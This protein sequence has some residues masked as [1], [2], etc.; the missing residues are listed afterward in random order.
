MALHSVQHT[1]ILL[2][3]GLLGST[4]FWLVTQSFHVGKDRLRDAPANGQ[5]AP[6][7]FYRPRDAGTKKNPREDGGK[8]AEDLKAWP[9]FLKVP[10]Q[11]HTFDIQHSVENLA[12]S[13][14]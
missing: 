6:Q 14:Y 5:Q 7:P 8:M 10:V 11:E 2:I 4:Y 3:N 13:D 12:T 9:L 1:F